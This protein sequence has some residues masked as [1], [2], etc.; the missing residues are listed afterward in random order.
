MKKYKWQVPG[1]EGA[2]RGPLKQAGAIL[3]RFGLA[4]GVFNEQL[5]QE[6]FS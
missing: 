6:I 4:V 5:A 3:D 2:L 1:V